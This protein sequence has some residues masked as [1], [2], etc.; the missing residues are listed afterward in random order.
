[1]TIEDEPVT[2]RVLVADDDR[3]A[4]L[5]S[6]AALRNDGFSVDIA[7]D[8]FQAL[9]AFTDQRP[10]LVILDILMPGMDGYEVCRAIRQL[11]DSE[12]VPVLMATGLEDIQSI[13]KAYD[14]GA[15]DFAPKPLNWLILVQR[16]RYMLR[17]SRAMRRVQESVRLL[18][19]AQGLAGICSW[20]WDLAHDKIQWSSE[21]HRLFDRSPKEI[22]PDIETLCGLIHTDDR[23]AFRQA[24][25]TAKIGQRRIG[26]EVRSANP[27]HSERYLD[28]R[29][30][31]V[32][33]GEGK[34]LFL[35][36]TFQDLSEHDQD[37]TDSP[38]SQ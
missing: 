11:P 18:E 3:T 22:S 4:I 8:G 28:S 16:V 35:V 24:L 15:T 19:D 14:A 7:R 21:T 23:A 37:R 9:Q 13:S 32:C 6:Q 36:G 38:L 12:H 2:P 30:E 34:P 31:T 20:E 25:E 17:A 10:D 1:M 29:M 5:L 27:D 33:D 26:L